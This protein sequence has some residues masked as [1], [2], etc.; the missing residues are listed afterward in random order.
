VR[1]AALLLAL[2]A[3]TPAWGEDGLRDFCA[4]RPGLGT[5][6]CTLDPGH[7]QVELGLIDWTKDQPDVLVAGDLLLRVGLGSHTEAQLGWTAF[8]HAAGRNGAGDVT[9]AL[10]QNLLSPGGSGTTFAI[11]PYATLPTGGHTI[12]AG[13]WSAGVR[14]PFGFSLS[15]AVSVAFTPDIEAAVDEDRNGRHLAYGGVAGIGAE[16]GAE[17]SATAELSLTRDED[18]AG[19]STEALAGVSLA[20]M[21]THNL[22]LDAGANLGLNQAAPDL[23]LYAGISRRF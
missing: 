9:L 11:M 6:A 7:V 22:Q 1:V 8:G 2:A 14:V 5:P 23:E 20:W 12:G 19:H 10:R 15:P 16:L 18:P 21:P 3:A 17:V 13:D 4:D